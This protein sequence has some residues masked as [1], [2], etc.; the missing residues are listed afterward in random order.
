MVG[1]ISN[2]IADLEK[3]NSSGIGNLASIIFSVAIAQACMAVA[4]SS[5]R[6]VGLVE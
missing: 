4:I 2:A 6:E 1:P 5:L 3:A